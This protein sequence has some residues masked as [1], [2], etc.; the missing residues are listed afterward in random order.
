MRGKV[1]VARGSIAENDRLSAVIKVIISQI[2]N[3]NIASLYIFHTSSVNFVTL[4]RHLDTVRS[5]LA[6]HGAIF[7]AFGRL[8][9]QQLHI[10]LAVVRS[11]VLTLCVIVVLTVLRIIIIVVFHATDAYRWSRTTSLA[12]SVHGQFDFEIV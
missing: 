3:D 9:Q 12:E 11:A 4:P 8:V 5:Q 1:N 7:E 6:R 10:F 2:S